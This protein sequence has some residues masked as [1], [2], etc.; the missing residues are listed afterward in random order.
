MHRATLGDVDPDRLSPELLVWAYQRG[1]FPMANPDTGALEWFSPDPRAILPLGAL[2]VP[3]RLARVLR[4]GHF[5]L[6]T[7]TAFERVM[8]EC[9]APRPKR[10]RS[11]ID[12]RLVSAYTALHRLGLAHSVEAYRAGELVGGIYGVQLGRAFFGESMF[13]AI[14]RGGRDASKVCLVRLVELLREHGFELFDVQLQNPHIARFGC[15]QIS[16]PSYLRQLARALAAP[17]GWPDSG[18]LA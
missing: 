13:S 8:R 14:E 16:R 2:H 4:S 9:A 15:T 6:A 10:E 17:G 5:A 7:D 12:E 18:T 3:R 1:L 11:W